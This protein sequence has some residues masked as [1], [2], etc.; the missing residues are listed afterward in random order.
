MTPTAAGRYPSPRA[1]LE[2][3][4]LRAKKSWGQN[5]L[6]DEGILDDIAR[7][8]A[9]RAGDPVVELGAGLG[10][11]DHEEGPDR[12]EESDDV[13]GEDSSRCDVLSTLDDLTLLVAYA[14]IERDELIDDVV[15]G[16]NVTVDAKGKII[17]EQK[18]L[19]RLI[20]QRR[21]QWRINMQ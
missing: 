9:P 2:K 19:T 3:Y 21:F 8:A 5:F 7:L 18:R 14:S 10:H 1:L 13:D 6:G 15:D 17:K 20:E 12:E 11:L 4:G 16:A